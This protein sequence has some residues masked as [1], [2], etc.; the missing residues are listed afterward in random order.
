[1]KKTITRAVALLTAAVT[2]LCF[3]GCLRFTNSLDLS[4]PL[5]TTNPFHT[6]P[7]TGV[8]E[9]PSSLPAEQDTESSGLPD[10]ES[11]TLPGTEPSSGAS[12]EVTTLPGNSTADTTAAGTTA[13]VSVK[14][15]IKS[16]GTTDYDVL[17]SNNCQISAELDNGAEKTPM[18]MAIGPEKLYISSEMEG[19]KIGLYVEGKKTF[20]YL[21]EKKSYLKL[22]NTVAKLIGIKPEEFTAMADELGF[23]SLPPLS[24]ATEM[25]DVTQDGVKCK[26]FILHADEEVVRV[27]LNGKKLVAIDYLN[28]AGAVESVMRFNYVKSGFPAM[29]PAGYSEIGYMDFAKILM[30]DMDT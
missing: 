6:E 3:A 18:E 26:R 4:A 5:T 20:I 8:S 28:D 1:M 25:Q 10:T 14:D 19:I 15:Y 7:S 24:D 27:Y 11:T 2:L 22:S 12:T 23:D 17:R 29:P 21:P 13:A 16:L 30:E 9:I